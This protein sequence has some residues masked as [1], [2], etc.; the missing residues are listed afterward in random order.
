MP[1]LKEHK[2]RN[3]VLFPLDVPD[4]VVL[5]VRENQQGDYVITVES[6]LQGTQCQYCGRELTQLHGQGRWLQLRHLPILGRRVYLQLRPQQY[7]CPH[8]GGKI[9]TQQ[10]DWYER[11]SPHTKAYDEYLLRLLVNSTVEDVSRKEQ[12][13]MLRCKARSCVRCV[14]E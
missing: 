12:S 1:N 3:M 14:P 4:L 5:D 10:L 8:C 7:V 11:K 6:T 13:A 9:T 2:S